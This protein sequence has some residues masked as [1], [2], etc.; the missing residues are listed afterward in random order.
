MRHS[1]A[2]ALASIVLPVP[3]GPYSSTPF[4]GASSPARVRAS[5]ATRSTVTSTQDVYAA[6]RC[7]LSHSGHLHVEC[8][9]LR[10]QALQPSTSCKGGHGVCSTAVPDLKSRDS[11]LGSACCAWFHHPPTQKR[12][13]W[14]HAPYASTVPRAFLHNMKDMYNLMHHL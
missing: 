3:G 10:L 2:T 11:G 5:N 8:C 4:Q 13:S 14:A 7:L 1:V 9:N 6:L 12:G